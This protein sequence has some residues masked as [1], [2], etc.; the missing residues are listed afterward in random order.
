M[1]ICVSKALARASAR[2]RARRARVAAVC[3]CCSFIFLNEAQ[4]STF[5]SLKLWRARPRASARVARASQ[6]FVSDA[7]IFSLMKLNYEHLC[8]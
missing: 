6:Q 7:P 2:V 3:Y 5:V 8:L 1:N 4:L